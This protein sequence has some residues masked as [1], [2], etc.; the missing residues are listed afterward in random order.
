[1]ALDSW[2]AEAVRTLA[3]ETGSI[4]AL[5]TMDA[6][7]HVQTGFDWKGISEDQRPRVADLSEVVERAFTWVDQEFHGIIWR[8][9]AALA[10]NPE[11]PLNRRTKP[12]RMA[13]AIVWVAL[14]ASGAAGRGRATWRA[15]DISTWFGVGPCSDLGRQLAGHIA[16]SNLGPDAHIESVASLTGSRVPLVGDIALLHSRRRR[17]LIERRENLRR[18]LEEDH[19]RRSNHQP[20]TQL[21]DHRVAMRA[22]P[23]RVRWATRGR[24]QGSREHIMIALGEL[25]DLELVA[26]SIPDAHRLL[27][28]VTAALALPHT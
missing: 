10:R 6:E 15:T 24:D 11:R 14:A 23:T 9:L 21:D 2:L 5:E 12:A 22:R 13:A 28:A 8:V 18:M 26:L 25:D 19:H 4:E 27:E 7:P 16:R 1:M 17:V 3:W 20:I